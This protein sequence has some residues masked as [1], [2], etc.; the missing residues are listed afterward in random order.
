MSGRT[1]WTALVVVI[2]VLALPPCVAAQDSAPP[3]KITV[4]VDDKA[5]VQGSVLHYAK[6]RASEVFEMSGIQ[7]EWIDGKEADRL[8]VIA[9]YMIV[10]MAEAPAKLKA[11]AEHLGIDVMGQGAPFIGRAYIYYDR[12]LAFRPIPPRDIISAL[13]DVMA[14]ELGHLMLPPGHSNAGIMRPTINMR[15]RRVETFTD[16]EARELQQRVRE[17]SQTANTH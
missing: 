17:G 13:G 14:H 4:R 6:A 12:V 2:S 9:P 8:K 11:E 15:S 10:I 5:G 7:I 16:S 3:V 1:R